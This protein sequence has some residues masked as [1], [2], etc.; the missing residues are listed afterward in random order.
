MKNHV[1]IYLEFFKYDISDFIPCEICGQKA[2]DIHHIERRGMGHSKKHSDKDI[3]ENLM[4]LCRGC[5]EKYGDKKQ[6]IN[7]LKQIHSEKFKT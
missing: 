6:F 5:H 3:P 7:F 4:A 1:K 2:V